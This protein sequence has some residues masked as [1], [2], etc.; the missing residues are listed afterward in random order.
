M[1][2]SDT[3]L[4]LP[5]AAFRDRPQRVAGSMGRCNTVCGIVHLKGGVYGTNRATRAFSCAEGGV[6]AAVEGHW[7]WLA[8]S[9]G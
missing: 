1:P 3:S 2:H 8:D 6:L 7:S 5:I 4:A 9:Y